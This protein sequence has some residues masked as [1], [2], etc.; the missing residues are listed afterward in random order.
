MNKIILFFK[1]WFEHNGI[2]K[3]L[4]AFAFLFISIVIVRRTHSYSLAHVFKI[5]G[6]ISFIYIALTISIFSIAGIAN[7]IKDI[8]DTKNK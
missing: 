6:M 7:S 4:V 8:K 1:N 2:F 3:I 5:I